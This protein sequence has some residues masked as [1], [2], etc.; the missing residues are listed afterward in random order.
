MRNKILMR[1]CG[2]EYM[3]V[4]KESD[5]Y[6]QKVSLYIDKKMTEIVKNNSK[7]STAQAAVLT[8]INVADDY[9]KTLEAYTV[10]ENDYSKNVVES[11]RLKK[12]REELKRDI[13]RSMQKLKEYEIKTACLETELRGQKPKNENI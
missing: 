4:G 2:K 6:M 11:E 3:V 9:F 13:E 5:E 8:A 12:E 7:L 10:I 1:I